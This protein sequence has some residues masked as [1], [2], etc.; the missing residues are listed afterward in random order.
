[1]KSATVVVVAVQVAESMTIE[2]LSSRERFWSH[3]DAERQDPQ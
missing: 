3:P 1:V 2:A